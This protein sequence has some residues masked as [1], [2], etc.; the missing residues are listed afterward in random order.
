MSTDSARSHSQALLALLFG[1]ICISFA[2]VFVKLI[3]TEA[4]GPTA[5][6]FWRTLFGAVVL[7]LMARIM[8]RKLTMRIALIKYAAVGGLLFALDLA[9][10]HRS[11][12]YCGAGMATILGNTQV[13]AVPLLSM[14]LFRERLS[15][16]FIIAASSALAGVTLLVGVG[17]ETE[18]TIT[19]LYG[20]GFGLANG[21]FYGAYL[22]TLRR[23]PR[24]DGTFDVI[25][26]TFWATTFCALFSGIS[27]LFEGDPMIPPDLYSWSIVISYG[28]V[29]QAFGW[30]AIIIALS[31]VPA[32]RAGLIL[33]LQPILATVW[34]ISFFSEQLQLSQ[35][36]GAAITVAAIYFGS[37]S[38]SAQNS[39]K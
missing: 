8:G 24:D 38:R 3:D 34:G 32:T 5:I 31:R 21:L 16:R 12:N 27:S 4:L 23:A 18:F 11:I 9:A 30:L 10:W 20:I 28:L 36:A 17:S 7:S 29:A 2:P 25:T 1:A 14:A 19:Y 39:D 35:I 15:G 6:A 26:F 13:F 37:I 22:I 33:L